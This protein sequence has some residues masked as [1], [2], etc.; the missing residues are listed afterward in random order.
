MNDSFHKGM[1]RKTMFTPAF[2]KAKW[3]WL[4]S[5]DQ[6]NTRL[7]LGDEDIFVMT[8]YGEQINHVILWLGEI[9]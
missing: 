1:K 3:F 2:L 9:L 8:V 4:K 6:P 5:R 7:K